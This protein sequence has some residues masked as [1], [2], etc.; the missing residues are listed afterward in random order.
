MKSFP[1]S[2]NE[3]YKLRDN[4]TDLVEGVDNYQNFSVGVIIDPQVTNSYSTQCMTLLACNMLARWC[5]NITIDIPSCKNVLPHKNRENFEQNLLQL[6]IEI[7]PY[8]KFRLE[9]VSVEKFDGVLVIGNTPENESDLTVNIHGDG[10]MAGCSYGKKNTWDY[11]TTGNPIGPSMASCMGVSE[12]FQQA[13]C[14]KKPEP[15]TTWKNLYNFTETN[16]LPIKTE[17]EPFCF[18]FDFGTIHQIGCGA[19]GSS[20]D[21]LISLTSWKGHFSLIDFDK[22]DFSNCNRSLPFTAYDAVA[23]NDKV[24]ICNEYLKLGNRSIDNIVDSYDNFTGTEQFQNSSPDLVL[25]LANEQKVWSTIQDNFPPLT[26]HAATTQSWGINFGRH[27]PIQEW[28]IMCRFSDEIESDFHPPCETGEIPSN[29]NQKILGTLPFLS[30][31]AA[32][33]IMA[34]MAKLANKQFPI[35]K[36]FIEMSLQRPFSKIIVQKSPV[37]NC[38]CNSQSSSLYHKYRQNSKFW[39]PNGGN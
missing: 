10:W 33:L 3:W 21:Y 11:K 35:N 23:K 39:F 17:N 22:I 20:L 5:R 37:T 29:N 30:P 36:N 27:I 15:Y 4:R 7:D 8:G 24:K 38:I 16:Q 1:L 18:D 2:E 6:M 12:L 26:F 14:Q 34:D 32:I 19:V 25:S 28:C 9:S 13:V 31:A